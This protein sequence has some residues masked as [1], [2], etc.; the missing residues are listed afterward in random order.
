M[1]FEWFVPKTGTAVLKGISTTARS[2]FSSKLPQSPPR[3]RFVEGGSLSF[4]LSLSRLQTP[5]PAFRG[6][7]SRSD[8]LRRPKRPLLLTR[9]TFRGIPARYPRTES[10]EPLGPISLA[11][12]LLSPFVVNG[13]LHNNALLAYS[14]TR[15]LLTS[16]ECGRIRARGTWHL[17]PHEKK[18]TRPAENKNIET[19]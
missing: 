7:P 19:Q 5:H 15:H 9:T 13:W 12:I 1:E 8:E 4:S 14:T 2:A 3:C 18:Q 10:I 16:A 6:N 17:V 11:P